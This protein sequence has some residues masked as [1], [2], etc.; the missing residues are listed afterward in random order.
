[1][2]VA[3]PVTS[4]VSVPTSPT[5]ET[6]EPSKV[7]VSL[8][9]PPS[10]VSL[11]APPSIVSSPAAGGDD[12]VARESIEG[13]ADLVLKLGIR[14]AGESE[15]RSPL[16]RVGPVVAARAGERRHDPGIGR[17]ALHCERRTGRRRDAIRWRIDC[18]LEGVIFVPGCGLDEID[19]EDSHFLRTTPFLA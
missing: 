4:K 9:A 13:I 12:V 5:I 3:A 8:P 18:G 14:A 11:S 15:L 10:S 6:S 16:V 19:G 7:I 17:H 1:M 2:I